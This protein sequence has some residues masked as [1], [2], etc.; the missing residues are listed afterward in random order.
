M[1]FFKP[2]FHFEQIIKMFDCKQLV[3]KENK[4]KKEDFKLAEQVSQT[5]TVQ[6]C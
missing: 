2:V 6:T 3:F 4:V 5:V 1:Q